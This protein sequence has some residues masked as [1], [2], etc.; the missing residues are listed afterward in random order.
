MR[1][2]IQKVSS[3]AVTVKGKTVGS[4]GIGLVMLVGIEDADSLEDIHWLVKK[5]T[6]CRI[7]EDETGKMNH[8]VQDVNGS[9]LVVSQFTLHGYT[10]KGNRPSF[11]R[12]AH[13]A[14]AKELYEKFIAVSKD[15]LGMSKVQSG[16]FGANMQVSLVNDGPVTIM[17]DSQNK[18]Y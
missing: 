6:Q 9:I 3:A 8:S 5:L 13:P 18:E 17:F 1:V 4:I 7:F 2:L 15:A 14:K 16:I 12:A 10:K 11:T